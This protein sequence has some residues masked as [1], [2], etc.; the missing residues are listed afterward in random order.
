MQQRP[1]CCYDN[2]IAGEKTESGTE[3]SGKPV[4][5]QG[6]RFKECYVMLVKVDC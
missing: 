2:G 4:C 1:T 5:Q 6:G 3:R